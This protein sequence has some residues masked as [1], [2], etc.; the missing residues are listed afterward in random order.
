M[1]LAAAEALATFDQGGNREDLSDV[2]SMMIQRDRENTLAL[3]GGPQGAATAT[4][5]EWPEGEL[6]SWRSSLA[7]NLAYD[8]TSATVAAGDGA[9]FR[10]GTLFKMLN[11]PEVMQ[12]TAI[13]TDTLTI[14]RGYGSTSAPASGQ[15][16]SGEEIIIISHPTQED[17]DPINWEAIVRTKAYNYTQIFYKTTKVSDSQ[18]AVNK[19]GVSSEIAWQVEQKLLEIK[20]EMNRNILHGIRSGDAGGDASYRSFGGLVEFINS[21]GGNVI[22]ASGAEISETRI[23]N[24]LQDIYTDGGGDQGELSIIAHPIQKRKISA[25]WKEYRRIGT[26]SKVGAK[27]DSYECDFGTVNVVMDQA[28]DE[29]AILVID[30]TRVKFMPLQSRAISTRPLPKTGLAEKREISGE[31]TLEVR[32]GLKAHGYMYDLSTS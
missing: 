6:T 15:Y 29:D 8:A 26:E 12:V 23:T 22:K 14:T 9:K 19:A 17:T 11:R 21:A 28:M 27:V 1:A 18:E 2:L 25:I 3:I 13:S 4:K 7:A 10:I 16:D 30:P 24:L 32:N 20:G 31:Y 5:H